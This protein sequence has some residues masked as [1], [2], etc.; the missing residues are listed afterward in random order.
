MIEYIELR[1]IQ[2]SRKAYIQVSSLFQVEEC[3]QTSVLGC[4]F[5]SH[6]IGIGLSGGA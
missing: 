4:D 3:I 6:I 2:G 1:S 5:T